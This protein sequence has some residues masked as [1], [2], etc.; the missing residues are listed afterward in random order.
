M[1]TQ[2]KTRGKINYF[3]KV[4]D[5]DEINGSKFTLSQKFSYKELST[6]EL[7]RQKDYQNKKTKSSLNKSLL[8]SKE[9]QKEIQKLNET[10]IEKKQLDWQ[11]KQKLKK[12]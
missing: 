8:L 10:I 11:E 12:F 5:N 1:K 6:E 9:I 2:A 4:W 3:F 7:I